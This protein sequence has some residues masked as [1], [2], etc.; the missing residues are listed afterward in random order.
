M[1]RK[2][3]SGT[4]A[5]A[6]HRSCSDENA[7]EGRTRRRTPKRPTGVHV[8]ERDGY[9]HLHG[10]IRVKGRGIRLRES[11]GL[12]A[13]PEHRDAAEELRR[14]KEQEIC[15]TVLYGIRPTVPFAVAA[16]G[17]LTRRR[18]RPLNAIDI[19]RIKELTRHFGTR[20]LAP[21]DE[22]EWAGVHR[23]ADEGPRSGDAGA[24]HRS[25]YE[26]TR[27]VPEA[28]AALAGRAPRNRTRSGGALQK[29]A[30]GA[31]RWRSTPRA[32][33]CTDRLCRTA[34]ASRSPFTT[35]KTASG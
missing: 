35:Q 34:P 18:K 11:T 27:L 9:F 17:Y 23:R 21:I 4:P 13:R 26:F 28:A 20:P 30:P 1:G 10:T 2:R 29:A 5:S 19:A 3:I 7:N 31:P 14:Q 12:P 33:C 15:N 16:E 32:N 6:R 22:E 25:R 24:L 8:I